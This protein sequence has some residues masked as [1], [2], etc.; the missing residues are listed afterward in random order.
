MAAFDDV[1]QFAKKS[2][3]DVHA[4]GG[5]LLHSNSAIK[6]AYDDAFG[7]NTMRKAYK[8]RANTGGEWIKQGAKKAYTMND[9]K[10]LNMTNILGT[11]AIGAVAART[12]SGGGITKDSNGNT[13]IV[14]LPFI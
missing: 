3:K 4:N 14:A 7:L 11:A 2:I 9:G 5:T 6:A 13:N 1:V 12:V 8:N 10:N